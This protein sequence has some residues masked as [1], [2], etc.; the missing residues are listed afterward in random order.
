[1][2][3]TFREVGGTTRI[4]LSQSGQDAAIASLARVATETLKEE[5]DIIKQAVEQLQ[6]DFSPAITNFETVVLPGAIVDVEAA[7]NTAIGA[8]NTAR[9]TAVSTIG[10]TE[11][12][13]IAAV[14]AA[15]DSAI[16]TINGLVAVAEGYKND[17][18]TARTGSETA[19][20]EILTNTGFIAVAGDLTGANT[21]G[22]V[23]GIKNEVVNLDGIKA[24]ITSLDGVK[25][26]IIALD[27][28][29]NNITSL[30][31]IKGAVTGVDGI[32]DAVTALD[33]IKTNI[34][35]LDTVKA[36]IVNVDGIKD[37]VVSVDG[38]KTEILAVPAQVTAAEAA[39]TLSQNWSQ[40]TLPGG[41]GTK[42]SKEH[43]EDAQ[44]FANEF[45]TA[46]TVAYTIA[47]EADGGWV[48]K[49]WDLDEAIRE[50]K[51]M[52]TFTDTAF[53]TNTEF[54]GVKL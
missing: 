31:S 13:A 26:E 27:G 32:K 36:Q 49:R 12:E 21:I 18:Q 30:D 8:I 23:A 50:A 9:D 53:W 19:R 17:A 38:I 48:R 34:T 41:A 44:T 46:E 39:A 37:E 40:G 3:I 52:G 24:N 6:I 47:V 43:A 54:G 11:T 33:G 25:N 28:I 14:N 45:L 2:S 4:V 51:G 20:D 7:R 42:S 10:S 16:S 15:R 1:M 29:K 22:Q 5:T 35:S